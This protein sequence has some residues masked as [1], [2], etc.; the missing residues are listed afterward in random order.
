MNCFLIGFRLP[1][2]ILD[3]LKG[4][5]SKRKGVGLIEDL[6]GSLGGIGM[7]PKEKDTLA[8][9]YYK[10]YIG[11]NGGSGPTLLIPVAKQL[12]VAVPTENNKG[13]ANARRDKLRDILMLES[14]L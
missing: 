1:S 6:K 4:V 5:K 7:G 13:K 14:Y 3:K 8:R 12:G 10:L 2:S 9:W 11:G